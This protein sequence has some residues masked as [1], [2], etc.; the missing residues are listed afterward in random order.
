V[1]VGHVDLKINL[2][3]HSWPTQDLLEELFF[4][5]EIPNH[6]FVFVLFSKKNI[7]SIKHRLL[8]VP[9]QRM[10]QMTLQ[11]Y[12]IN[13]KQFLKPGLVRVNQPHIILKR[14]G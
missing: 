11:N 3:T 14:C 9:K 6:H 7:L 10:F 13:V 1:L 2:Y 8:R 5:T 12:K 4:S